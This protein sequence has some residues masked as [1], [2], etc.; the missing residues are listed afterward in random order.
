MIYLFHPNRALIYLKVN[1]NKYSILLYP[2]YKFIHFLLID[3]KLIFICFT[4][5]D[6]HPQLSNQLINLSNSLFL[7]TYNLNIKHILSNNYF[8]FFQVKYDYL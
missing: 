8:Y 5:K 3:Q 4:L 1:S 2:F 7:F 6:I